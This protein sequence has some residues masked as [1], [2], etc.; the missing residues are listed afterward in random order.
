MGGIMSVKIKYFVFGILV[1]LIFFTIISA[2]S[3]PP[4]NIGKYQ[5]STFLDSGKHGVF[6]CDT[7]T[8][9]VKLIHTDWGS[10][11]YNDLNKPFDEIKGN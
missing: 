11:Y 3:T 10:D 8:G 2:T 7:E 6:I 5:I 9:V 4:S 1:S